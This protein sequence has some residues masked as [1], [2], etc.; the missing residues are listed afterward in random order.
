MIFAVSL[1]LGFKN[2]IF[3]SLNHSYVSFF[4]DLG[5]V[6]ILIPNPIEDPVKYLEAF[7]LDGIIL[8]GGIDISPRLYNNTDKD[9]S[10]FTDIR[11]FTEISLIRMSVERKLLV[12]G[13]CRGMQ[14]INVYFGGKIVQ[15]IN[16]L[17]GNV[18][19]HVAHFH[20]NEVVDDRIYNFLKVRD[21]LVNSF[22]NHGISKEVL[23]PGLNV[24]SVSKADRIVEGIYH[25][26]LPIL[27]I[28]WHPEREGSTRDIDIAL[29]QGFFKRA[30]W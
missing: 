9:H 28:Q 3:D 17:T 21:F 23:A 8:T 30:F 4:S 19:N 20:E 13:I 7:D 12:F 2:E 5:V 1:N 22:H 14:L 16:A 15:N 24:F 11:D 27:G 26:E 29:I 18:V 25:P 6:P 10:S